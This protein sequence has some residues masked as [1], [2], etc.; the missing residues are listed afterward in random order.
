M[1]EEQKE[2]TDDRGALVLPPKPVARGRLRVAGA[3]QHTVE[4]ERVY[5]R[6]SPGFLAGD[7]E[8]SGAPAAGS[9]GAVSTVYRLSVAST[10]RP[11]APVWTIY[12]SSDSGIPPAWVHGR[13]ERRRRPGCS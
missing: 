4:G 2:D 10:G 8:G 3:R 11:P 13:P 1:S 12:L 7:R 5:R 9:G 6:L